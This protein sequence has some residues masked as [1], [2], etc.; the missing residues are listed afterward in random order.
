MSRETP[1]HCALQ[2]H[3]L[4]TPLYR[5]LV[6]AP[7]KKRHPSH[8]HHHLPNRQLLWALYRV[9]VSTS[10]KGCHP[11]RQLLKLLYRVLV[12]APRNKP[13]APSP[14]KPPLL[15]FA[16]RDSGHPPRNKP[17]APS[18]PN[19]RYSDLLT[20]ITGAHPGIKN[21]HTTQHLAPR[22]IRVTDSLSR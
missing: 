20:A 13:T 17:T 19:H 3:K 9:L 6:S 5:V 16:Y 11:N 10:R 7:R 22:Q 1:Q 21:R 12:S 14:P 2:K 8:H 15:G 4:L 18:P